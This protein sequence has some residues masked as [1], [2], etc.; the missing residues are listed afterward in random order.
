[1]R[2]CGGFKYKSPS[3]RRRNKLRKEKFLAKF[4]RHP[5]LMRIP[6]LEPGQTPTPVVLGAPIHTAISTA[7][8]THAEEMVG[9]MKKLHHRWNYLAGEAEDA[10]KQ[11]DRMSNWVLDLKDQGQIWKV[12]CVGW[13]WRSEGRKKSWHSSKLEK[14]SGRFLV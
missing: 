5:L 11:R 7:F 1:M 4:R 3:K 10:E 6:F 14:E 8:I 2:F 12:L 9:M 13:S